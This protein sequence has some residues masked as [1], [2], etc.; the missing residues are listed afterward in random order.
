[1]LAEGEFL[2]ADLRVFIQTIVSERRLYMRLDRILATARCAEAVLPAGGTILVE[3]E[4]SG[5]EMQSYCYDVYDVHQG[6]RRLHNVPPGLHGD[7]CDLADELRDFAIDVEA[8]DWHATTRTI[9]LSDCP[10]NDCRSF[11]LAYGLMPGSLPFWEK[12]WYC[13]RFL[14]RGICSWLWLSWLW[15]RPRCR[16][17]L[18]SAG[19]LARALWI[20]CRYRLSLADLRWLMQ[21]RR[22]AD[23]SEDRSPVLLQDAEESEDEA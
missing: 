14:V 16:S 2:G 23:T 3:R 6:M 4:P 7:L 10:C 17:L 22:Q 15:V 1:M 20:A 12:L 21:L 13:A 18:M 9:D 11:C 5:D 19:E 8:L